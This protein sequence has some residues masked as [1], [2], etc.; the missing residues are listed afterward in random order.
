MNTDRVLCE[1]HFSLAH[2]TDRF[3]LVSLLSPPLCMVNRWE[4]SHQKE[5]PLGHFLAQVE[6]SKLVLGDL[7]LLR[8]AL[9]KKIWNSWRREG[10]TV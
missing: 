1:N 10:K 6:P 3:S 7:S 9:G 8:K 5:G 4:D 2:R